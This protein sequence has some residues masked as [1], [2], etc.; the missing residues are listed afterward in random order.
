M[1]IEDDATNVAMAAP[2][3]AKTASSSFYLTKNKSFLPGKQYI[4]DVLKC[5]ICEASGGSAPEPPLKHYPGLN[6][7]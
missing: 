2:L 3:F 5:K 4:S 6:G 1:G 7:G